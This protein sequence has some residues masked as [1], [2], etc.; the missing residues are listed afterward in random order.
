MKQNEQNA[1]K[2]K[3]KT[4]AAQIRVQKG[5][6]TYLVGHLVCDAE[7]F[8]C[9]PVADL[10]ELDLPSTM[11]THFEDPADLLNFTLTITPDDGKF[12]FDRGIKELISPTK[13]LTWQECTRVANSR[14]P[15]PLTP[16]T[17]MNPPK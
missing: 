3:P 1:A 2:R 16:T 14:S 7:R 11:Q 10:T 15:S 13:T 8:P 5:V 17:P 4:S 12:E 6:L 9:A